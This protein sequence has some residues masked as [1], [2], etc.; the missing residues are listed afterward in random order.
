MKHL[1]H[2][3]IFYKLPFK[4]KLSPLKDLYVKISH[5]WHNGQVRCDE[6]ESKTIMDCLFVT[7]P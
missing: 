6:G 5:F 7:S 2:L 3:H 4:E 1:F